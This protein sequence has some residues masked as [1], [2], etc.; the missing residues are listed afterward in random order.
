MLPNHQNA[1]D[2]V[3]THGLSWV[4]LNKFSSFC[5][6][7]NFLCHFSDMPKKSLGA[8]FMWPT[9][10]IPLFNSCDLYLRN[11]G[12]AKLGKYLHIL[13]HTIPGMIRNEGLILASLI[14]KDQGGLVLLCKCVVPHARLHHI[15]LMYLIGRS[16]ISSEIGY[17]SFSVWKVSL[18][19]WKSLLI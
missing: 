16:W 7:S 13:F 11:N 15:A 4:Y 3:F 18:C 9:Q 12:Y 5:E 2:S 10:H 17:T 1:A 8:I 19:R 6:L 14:C